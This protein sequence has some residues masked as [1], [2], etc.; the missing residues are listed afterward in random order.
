M[1]LR[2]V[3]ETQIDAQLDERIRQGLCVCFP[4]DVAVFR[5]TRH[6]HGVPPAFCV[7]AEAAEQVVAHAAVV[8]RTIR[9]GQ[10]SVRVA[11]LQ[12]VFVLPPYRGQGLSDRVVAIAME[13]S[14]RR[15]FEYGVLFCRTTLER[16]YARCGWRRLSPRKITRVDESGRDTPL[17]A[18]SITMCFPISAEPFP[19]ADIHLEGN[20]W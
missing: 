20:D 12:N 5:R 14:G 2:V 9:V 15:G 8:D 6:W 11:G 1:H 18:K 3:D 10:R 16:V 7:I 4:P 13:E 19:A 17:P